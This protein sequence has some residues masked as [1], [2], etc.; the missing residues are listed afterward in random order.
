MLFCVQFLVLPVLISINFAAYNIL[1]V[2]GY[3]FV[4]FE[5]APAAEAAVQSLQSKGIQAQMAKVSSCFHWLLR[6][7]ILC[8]VV[9][10]TTTIFKSI[11]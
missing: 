2:A 4:D 6:P 11:C 9:V 10:Q 7:H 8:R 5:L 1:T 3:G